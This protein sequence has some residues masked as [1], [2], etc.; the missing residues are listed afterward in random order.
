MADRET[1]FA[2]LVNQLIPHGWWVDEAEAMKCL[3]SPNGYGI[4]DHQLSEERLPGTRASY[5]EKWAS[6]QRS[7]EESEVFVLMEVEIAQLARALDTLCNDGGLEHWFMQRAEALEAWASRRSMMIY[8]YA[9]AAPRWCFVC[10]HPRGGELW[11]ETHRISKASSQAHA[12]WRVREFTPDTQ[13]TQD[14]RCE[15]HALDGDIQTILESLDAMLAVALAWTTDDLVIVDVQ[16]HDNINPR[17]IAESQ[18]HYE[19][20]LRSL[21]LPKVD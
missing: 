13:T 17:A 4:C 1:N 16:E 19:S 2:W 8:R 18:K 12:L 6:T 5:F 7:I 3:E 11:V 10:R 20:H 15:T 9:T 21:S 14:A